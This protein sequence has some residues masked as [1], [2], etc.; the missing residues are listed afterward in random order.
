M[1]LA[2][3]CVLAS[4]AVFGLSP[5]RAVAGTFSITP[6]RVDLSARAGTGV[7]TLRNQEDRPL[8]V[9]AQMHSWQQVEGKD[10]LEPTREILVAPAV[11][12]VP[13]NGAQVVRIALRR[14]PEATTELSYRLVLTEVPPQAEPGFTGLSFALQMSLPVFVA[15]RQKAT[16]ELRWSATQQ[17]D[18]P[19]LV[20][21]HNVGTAHARVLQLEFAPL[22]AAGDPVRP[23]GAAYILPGQSRIWAVAD[24]NEDT[25]KNDR[26]AWRRLRVKGTAED[27]DF[28]AELQV[29]TH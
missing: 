2:L 21:T 8:V 13:P 19:L 28:A 14:E 17:G 22:D 18:G 11:F 9:Q 15:A 12:T 27:G 16:P 24:E 10:R 25:N 1:R 5:A 20:T 29:A 23:T 4:A 6:I 3:V 26:A 7:V